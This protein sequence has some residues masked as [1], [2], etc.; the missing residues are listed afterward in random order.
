[1][2]AE[3][4]RVGQLIEYVNPVVCNQKYRELGLIIGKPDPLWVEVLWAR[5]DE[6]G[7]LTSRHVI[8]LVSDIL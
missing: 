5:G 4:I 2:E 3:D 6:P 7:A 1:M 8:K